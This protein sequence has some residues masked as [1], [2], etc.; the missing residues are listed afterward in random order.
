MSNWS[1]SDEELKQYFGNRT[2][3]RP[4]ADGGDGAPPPPKSRSKWRGY[5]EQRFNDP[6]K[7]QAAF[8][9]SIIG[10]AIGL[11][12]LLLLL[13]AAVL[14]FNLPP[15]EA[16][17]SP[18]LSLSTVAYTADGELL[19]RYHVQQNRS[20]APYDSISS[21]VV[22]A[23][24]AT[25]DR[26][27]YSHW[28]ID[29]RGWVA[30]A[31]G[32]LLGQGIRGASTI[33]MQLARNLYNDI[34]FARTPTRKL[35]EMLTAIQ[36]E[37]RYTKREII[38]MY[39][40]T[41][42]FGGNA[43]GIETAAHTFF[44]KSAAQLDT[45]EGAT[46]VGMLQRITY[47][48]PVRNPENAKR[49]RNTVLALMAQ[50]GYL[51]EAE[52]SQLR[53]RPVET[54]YQ[55]SEITRSLA[56]YFAMYVQDWLKKWGKET[57]HNLY[58]DG[59]VVYTTLDSRMQKLANEAVAEE[60]EGL[61]AVVDYD[62]GRP[63]ANLGQSIEPYKKAMAGCYDD[64]PAT[65]CAVEPFGHF[66][67]TQENLVT[68][69]IKGTGHY[70]ELRDAG[71]AEADALSRLR[72]DRAFQDSLK[73]VKT[74]L[75]VGLLALDPRTGQVKVWVGGRDLK[76]DWF[77]HVVTAKRQPGSTFK[78]FVYIAA[79]DNGYSPDMSVSSEP[80]TWYGTGE[81]AGQT[82]SP[83]NMGG[84]GGERTLRTGLA[85]SN[86]LVTARLMD[87]VKPR[88]VALY[89][90]RMGIE[91][92]L[93]PADV[94]PDCYNALALGTSDVNLLE[95]T[96]AYATLAN[97]GLH[98]APT[99]VTRVEDRF[100][101]VLYEAE[102]VPQEA[103]PEETAYTVI[104][105]MRGA[106]DYG[107][108]VRL[109]GQY[110]IPGSY[111]FAAKTGTTQSSADG[112]FMIV[113]PDLVVGSWTGFNDRRIAFRSEWWGQ[114]AHNAMFV[115][116]NFLSRLIRAGSAGLNPENT[117]PRPAYVPFDEA[118][119]ATDL[120]DVRQQGGGNSGRVGW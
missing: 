87:M 89:A 22:N 69:Y 72:G 82:W 57:G 120:D 24:I 99:A 62:W 28:G 117:F 76:T 98:T 74:R 116:G 59:L 43:Y 113:H 103:L 106:V 71:V 32:A 100:G 81:C 64:D 1:Y 75:E 27:F 93:F 110:S 29:M 20:W 66:W 80:Y 67:R 49:R 2:A 35:R 40:N 85:T 79:V 58:T 17:E 63:G 51:S 105:M 86:N 30:V 61:Q 95:L 83:G 15:L 39:L 90:R 104:D 41:V 45:L 34:G 97:G 114:G 96:T 70:R 44:D 47:F 77:D 102:P 4:G 118:M 8:W 119:P 52:F 88:N 3:R 16:I 33:T 108:A 84:G 107:T 56:P 25:E 54:S 11:F 5:F 78:P 60:M 23:L 37:R 7:A 18:D 111:D 65:D 38:E 42:Q 21:T 68:E 115:T 26:R 50:N 55:S 91:S 53:E 101:N 92:D 12:T 31:K 13:M 6:K 19:A 112:W 109:R 9:L 46:L 73:A 94:N 14:A 48:N 36:I 10:G